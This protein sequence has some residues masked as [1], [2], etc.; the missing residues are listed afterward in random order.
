MLLSIAIPTYNNKNT[1]ERAICS[2]LQQSYTDEYEIVIVDNHSTDGSKDL[3]QD[4]AN[5]HRQ[6]ALFRNEHTV[7]MY[8][9][10]NKC[11][12]YAQG[13]YVL[14][15]HSD[16]YLNCNALT[17]LKEKIKFR[18]FPDKYVLWGSSLF[19]DF[20]R[21]ISY[22]KIQMNMVLAGERAYIPFYYG[23]L[24]P[25]GTCYSRNAFLQYEGFLPTKHRLAPSDLTTMLY[26]ASYGFEFEMMDRILFVREHASTA[27]A[28]LLQQKEYIDAVDDAIEALINKIGEEKFIEIARYSLCLEIPPIIFFIC[29]ARRN[30]YRKQLLK[31]YLKNPLFLNLLRKQSRTLLE[32]LLGFRKR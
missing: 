14:F 1:I 18:G 6:I 28:N 10:H 25:S 19:R 21:S 5:S 8:E 4:I 24:T 22:A 15:C 7:S 26:L 32:N 23:G 17:L 20:Y 30:F 12:Q 29:L 9:N 3:L 2:C 31:Q 16:D 11:L 27:Q 13:Q